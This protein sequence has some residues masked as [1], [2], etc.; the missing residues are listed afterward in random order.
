MRQLPWKAALKLI[1][2]SNRVSSATTFSNSSRVC[3]HLYLSTVAPEAVAPAC[4][5]DETQPV[6]VKKKK[7]KK[8]KQQEPV[9]YKGPDNGAKKDTTHPLPN[10]YHPQYVEAAWQEWWEARGY[11]TSVKNEEV[12]QLQPSENKR[13][14]FSVVL[15]P[16]NVTG[17]L[18]IGHALTVSVQDAMCRWRRMC[19]D[20]VT[21][22][23]GF[24]HAGI[25]TQSVVEKKIWAEEGKTRED[26]GRE[27][28]QQRV[29]Q[30]KDEKGFCP[31]RN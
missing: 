26:V 21:W 24:D 20:E 19:G 23:P 22:V 30:W 14:K 31:R 15:P 27:E 13:A 9:I 1:S 25:A 7:K 3:H 12:L 10:A 6:I 2:P 8:N 5:V 4:V 17:N 18:H 11:F 28:F 16:P 29:L